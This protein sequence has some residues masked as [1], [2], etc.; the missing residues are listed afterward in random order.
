MINGPLPRFKS[1]YVAPLNRMSSYSCAAISERPQLAD[2]SAPQL[3]GLRNRVVNS[4]CTLRFR[5]RFSYSSKSLSPYRPYASA[6]KLPPDTPVITSIVSSSRMRPRGLS[7]SVLRSTSST[8]YANAAARVPPPENVR[9]TR[10]SFPFAR[11]CSRR[12][13]RR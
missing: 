12:G 1:A 8:P 9:M 13:R 5:K 11:F 4:P 3:E 7:T 10:L 2:H 6:V